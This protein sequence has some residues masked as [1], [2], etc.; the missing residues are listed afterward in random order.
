M[1][2]NPSN[3]HLYFSD[4]TAG[5]IYELD[6]GANGLYNT[7]DDMITSFSTT[8]FGSGDPEGIAYDTWQG[9][10]FVSDGVNVEIY[11][12]DPGP[13]GLFEG[14]GGDDTITSFDAAGLGPQDPEG[15]EFNP[16]S[17]HLYI[18]K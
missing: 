11:D 18:F 14:S 16:D 17:G 3:H 10:L 4:D 13:N 6:P 5:R 12:I 9:H 8:T 1:A 7:S 2:Y 15:V